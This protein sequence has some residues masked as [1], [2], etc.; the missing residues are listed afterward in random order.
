MSFREIKKVRKEGNI[1]K[2]TIPKN[3]DIEEGDFV[4]IVKIKME[5]IQ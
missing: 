5:D 3:C 4:K 2:I 1:K